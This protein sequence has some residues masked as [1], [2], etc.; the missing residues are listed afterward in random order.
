MDN[1]DFKALH[2]KLDDVDIQR[3]RTGDI[4][5]GSYLPMGPYQFATYRNISIAEKTKL[6][7]YLDFKEFI[8]NEPLKYDFNVPKK[9]RRQ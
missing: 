5:F 2:S 4:T 6:T 8:L 3:N 1:A 9:T 7:I